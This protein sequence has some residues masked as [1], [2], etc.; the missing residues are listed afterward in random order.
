MYRPLT[1]PCTWAA[2]AS[3]ESYY[4]SVLN[5]N[6]VEPESKSEPPGQV[7]T[8]RQQQGLLTSNG[9][10]SPFIVELMKNM[11]YE[12]IPSGG[13]GNKMLMLLEGRGT[14][15]IQDRYGVLYNQYLLYT[16]LYYTS[17]GIITTTTLLLLLLLI[18]IFLL[19]LL[20]SL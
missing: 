12:R 17:V 6:Q 16:I 7:H 10:I 2:G 20:L 14:A 11:N 1:N 9:N 3:T 18:L 4:D 19:Q 5:H 13:A 15:Y 8:H